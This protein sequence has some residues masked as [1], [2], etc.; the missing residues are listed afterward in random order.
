MLNAHEI[1]EVV[2]LIK[3]MRIILMMQTLRN[4]S[5]DTFQ[6]DNNTHS[7][8]RENIKMTPIFLARLIFSDLSIG[9]GKQKRTK[10]VAS[11]M[12]KDI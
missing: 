9:I 12:P 1:S 5:Q 4:V 11:L 3:V 7:N 10:S 6:T 2:L 8:P